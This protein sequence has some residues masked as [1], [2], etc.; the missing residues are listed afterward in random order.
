MRP[1]NKGTCSNR[2]GWGLLPWASILLLGVV[3][4]SCGA[5][6]YTQTFRVS[7]GQ[8]QGH[9]A[10]PVAGEATLTVVVS[11]GPNTTICTLRASDGILLRHHDLDVHGM[12]LGQGDGLL[13]VDERRGA[14]GYSL[15]LCAV[16]ISDGI[17]LWCQTRLTFSAS[18]I[19]DNGLVYVSPGDRMSVAAV[20][21]R[22]G[23]ILWRF[24]TQAT[25]PLSV[26]LLVVPGHGVVYASTFQN[27]QADAS[28]ANT[29]S[30][31]SQSGPSGVCALQANNGQRLWCRSFP[32]E[33]VKSMAADSRAL[34]VRTSNSTVYALNLADGAMHWHTSL[35]RAP[36][37]YGI[38]QVGVA[39]GV[40]FTNAP[41][42]GAVPN[43]SDWVDALR[44]SDGKPLW[45]ASYADLIQ[46]MTA[47]DGLFYLVT[48]GGFLDVLTLLNGAHAWSQGA[49]PAFPSSGSSTIVQNVM[50]EQNVAYTLVNAS[51]SELRL[52]ALRAHDGAVL[53]ADQGCANATPTPVPGTSTSTM[54]TPA[55]TRCYWMSDARLLLL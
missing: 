29:Q 36:S 19:T 20:S 1:I 53:W 28:P 31:S 13:Y 9:N 12:V 39:H 37:P 38:L 50:V 45:S 26:P 30:S 35:M 11:V 52:L 18:I 6:P 17:K 16:R 25:F 15:A 23:R 14:Q 2:K 51:S 55:S 48:E 49:R 42:E 33:S 54:S 5:L 43:T 22:D 7:S 40:V 47:T 41:G 24:H 3:V 10:H 21:E 44:A 32:M 34:Y 46:S 4:C 8:C 27:A